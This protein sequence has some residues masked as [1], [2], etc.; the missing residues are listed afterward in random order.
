[1]TLFGSFREQGKDGGGEPADST[2]VFEVE[3]LALA[4]GDAELYERKLREL[5]DSPRSSAESLKKLALE[6]SSILKRF[7]D[8][9][10]LPVV[11][12][13]VIA[14]FSKAE[15]SLA[16]QDADGRLSLIRQFHEALGNVELVLELL[17]A[18]ARR[19]P[20]HEPTSGFLRQLHCHRLDGEW[21][22]HEEFKRKLGF[23]YEGDR[24]M[25]PERKEFLEIIKRIRAE[26]Q[27]NLI[28]RSRTDREYAVLAQE[29]KVENGMTREELAAA[30]GLPDRVLR[31]L[32]DSREIDQWNYGD[33]RVYLLNG[34]VV[35]KVP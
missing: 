9:D 31:E 17:R 2:P 33:R 20:L 25:K 6:A 3:K 14:A 15:T 4:P 7:G 29:G 27:I 30:L 8:Q 35:S 28:L 16:A 12:K 23:I 22:T 18:Q 32:E 24:W 21:F 11:R 19:Y 13:M 26:N 5:L 34:L 10:L 1:L